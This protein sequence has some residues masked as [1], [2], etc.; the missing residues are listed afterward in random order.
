MTSV[1]QS[2]TRHELWYGRDEEPPGRE[3]VR[4]GDLTVEL[5]GPLIRAVRAGDV[6]IL[7]AVYMAVRDERWDTVPGSVSGLELR[8]GEREFVSTF[9]LAHLQP[10][11]SF[12]WKG[13]IEGERT[14]KL[15][16][17]FEGVAREAFRYCR[18][19]FCLLHPPA[20]YAGQRYRGRSPDGEVEGTLPLTIGPQR[21]E[22]GLDWPL[23][24]SVSEL[25]VSL[26][27]GLQVRMR[28]E[29]DL[30]EME[31][32]RNWSDASFK[33]Y[34]TP[35]K[36]GY[37]FAA[38]AGQRFSQKVTIQVT[39]RPTIS[40]ADTQGPSIALDMDSERPLPPIGF[41][42]PRGAAGHS[43]AET[44]LL[45]CARPSHLRVN[46]DLAGDG[47]KAV[48]AAGADSVRRL[49]CRLEMAA[50]AES[51]GQ[52]D[53]LVTE[54]E[55]DSLLR[56]LVF[57][58]GQQVTSPAMA[59]HARR[60]CA[61]RGLRVPVVGG[62]DGW[63]AELNRDRPGTSA[64]DGLVYSVTP[65]VHTFDEESIVQSLEAQPETVS[66]AASFSS[67]LPIL[68]GPV[69]LR[70]RDPIET[71]GFS[72]DVSSLPFSVDPRQSSLFAAA[73]TVG[74]ISALAQAGAASLT[75]YETVGCRGIIP[76]DGPLP[77]RHVF[78]AAP[79]G[80][81]YAMFHVF[82]DV[83]E[84]RGDV[85]VLRCVSLAPSEVAALALRVGDRL[86]ILIAN[87]TPTTL[88]VAP[89]PVPGVVELGVR[90]L[91]EMTAPEALTEPLA[92]RERPLSPV[93]LDELARPL[94]LRPFAVA[95]LDGRLPGG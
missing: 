48:L 83:R 17:Q 1:K 39:G 72:D 54:L 75:Y 5:E 53:G 45:G 7:R 68:V 24:D 93:A 51:E 89:P 13:R 4:A 14:G 92:F 31:D 43:E 60:L 62:T 12:D 69:T 85:Q 70:P 87:L 91:D 27:S 50:F 90:V 64:M 81:A 6:E 40:V 30:F 47:W 78:A 2:L 20:E 33:T 18:I 28:F 84:L 8:R 37:P 41:G 77:S 52:L 66:T 19:G 56:L 15:T 32:Q 79:P 21:F 9:E 34:C 73:W 65:Q 74:S 57:T 58:R 88:T 61:E 71:E 46:L 86:R 16:F 26:A 55:P 94:E 42:M 36:L 23:F 76:G 22:D 67:G 10:P 95:R 25:D 44:R 80:G 3:I 11:V 38:S 35:L 63:F 59:A 49:G 29:G 82:A